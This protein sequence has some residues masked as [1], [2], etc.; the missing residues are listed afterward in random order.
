MNTGERDLVGRENIDVDFSH[1]TGD[2][3]FPSS[4]CIGSSCDGKIRIKREST[5]NIKYIL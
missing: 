1:F 5:Q 4:L 3:K 2:L